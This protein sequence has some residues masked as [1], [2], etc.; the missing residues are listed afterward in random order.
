MDVH[1]HEA[2]T[3]GLRRRAIDV[4]RAQEDNADRLPDAELLTRATEPGRVLF[5]QDEDLLM[6]GARRQAAGINFF[7]DRVRTANKSFRR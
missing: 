7:G 5:S 1:V 2:I 4:L 3:R 6:E